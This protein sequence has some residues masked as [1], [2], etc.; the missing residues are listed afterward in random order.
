MMKKFILILLIIVGFFMW[1]NNFVTE[2][3]LLVFLDEHPHSVWTPRCLYFIGNI[4]FLCNSHENAIMYFYR[5]VDKYPETE[6]VIDIE[7]M[8]G[9][10]YEEMRKYK[11]AEEVYK[12]ILDKYPGNKYTSKIQKKMQL[13]FN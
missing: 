1:L 10:S 12:R 5:I 6:R 2:G 8:M 9:R 4:Y 11:E 3:K 7:Y 13:I